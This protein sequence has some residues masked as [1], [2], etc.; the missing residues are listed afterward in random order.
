MEYALV[1]YPDMTTLREFWSLYTKKSIEEKNEL[2]CLAPFYDTV[3]S[4]RKTLSKGHISI[5]VSKYESVD[6]SLIIIDSL[7]AYIDNDGSALAAD[8]LWKSIRHQV[9]HAKQLEKNGTS[10][11][12]DMGSFLFRNRI[13]GL[14]DYELYLPTNFD[15]D[16]KGVCM[17]HQKDFD[18]LPE[19]SKKK[20][21][22]H[23]QISIEI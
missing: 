17:Y 5:E 12:G 1:V 23:H 22:E 9:K 21:V 2:V 8:L 10:I 11:I 20:L 14:V 18:R 15:M 16:L 3:D 19:D 4:V 6:K 13:Q 7:K